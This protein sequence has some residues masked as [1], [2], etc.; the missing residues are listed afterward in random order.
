MVKVP[1]K[2]KKEIRTYCI[3]TGRLDDVEYA[4]FEHTTI[5]V[6]YIMYFY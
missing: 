6:G 4:K 3:K 1:N 5:Y 2:G